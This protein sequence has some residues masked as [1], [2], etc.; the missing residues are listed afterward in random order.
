[1]EMTFR[2][3]VLIAIPDVLWQMKI[4]L[5]VSHLLVMYIRVCV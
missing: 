5:F 4:Q 1:M 3:L 2:A